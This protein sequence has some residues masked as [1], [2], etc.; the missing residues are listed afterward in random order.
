MAQSGLHV[1]AEEGST[2]C[3]HD[4]VLC[5]IGDG[6]SI[7]ENLSTFSSHLT[8][9]LE[10]L[11]NATNESLVLMDELGT[12]TDPAEGMGIAVAVLDELRQKGCLFLA[13][14]HYPEVKDFAES[15][16]GIINAR[17]E[18]DRE[19]LQPLYKLLIGEAGESCALYI[20]Q[21]LGFPGHLLNRARK[22][23]YGERTSE[24]RAGSFG[25]FDE[26]ETKKVEGYGDFEENEIKTTPHYTSK[27][28]KEPLK[29]SAPLRSD[30]FNIGDSV[31]VYPQKVLGIVYMRAN[32]KGELGVQIQGKKQLINH[33]RVK[34]KAPA[35]EM[36]PEDYDFSIIFDTVANR[37]ARHQMEKKHC[38][39]LVIR[40]DEGVK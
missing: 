5:D 10:I 2:F 23:A 16:E 38:P 9:I 40:Y 4:Y 39:D 33:K 7:I 12:G 28:Q 17:M 13:T 31:M 30:K 14:T 18:F 26:A 15:T 27:I 20:A 11:N 24:K 22:E 25:V 21:R 32:E 1:P 34:L 3:M 6:Q 35:S 19:T 29:N 8:N 36:Y 37:K